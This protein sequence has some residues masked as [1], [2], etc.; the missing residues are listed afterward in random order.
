MHALM[1]ALGGAQCVLGRPGVV[2]VRFIFNGGPGASGPVVP[3]VAVPLSAYF[4]SESGG[5]SNDP[6]SS[7]ALGDQHMK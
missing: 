1:N 5:V 2:L 6:K 3:L 4:F 7:S